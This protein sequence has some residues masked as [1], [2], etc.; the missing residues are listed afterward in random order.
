MS[1]PLSRRVFLMMLG[2]EGV[3]TLA[4]REGSR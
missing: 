3:N 2:E 4:G 1:L